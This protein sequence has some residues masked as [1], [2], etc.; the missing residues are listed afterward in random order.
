MDRNEIY[1]QKRSKVIVIEGMGD[2][3]DNYVA[4]VMR[5]IESLGFIFSRPLFDRLKTLTEPQLEKFYKEIV[6]VLK[7]MVGA[8][9]RHKP[10]YPNFPKQVME[11][12]EVEL[13]LNA[14]AHYWTASLQ[15]MGAIGDTWLPEYEAEERIPLTEKHTLKIINIG[16]I[17]DFREI[18]T[19]LVGSKSSISEFDKEIV[20][21]FVE[22]FGSDIEPILPA[23][24]PFKEQLCYVASLFMKSGVGTILTKY[25][26]TATDVLRIAAGM[27]DG[28]I[29]LAKPC[30]F[31][32]FSRA[33]RKFLLSLLENCDNITEDMFRHEKVWVK[34]LHSLHV[35]DYASRFPKA[36]AA[37]DVLRNNKPFET[38]NSKVEKLICS[39]VD[40]AVKLLYNRPSD[41]ARR[42]DKILRE[43]KNPI[44]AA[45]AL[46]D[47]S[48][49]ISTPVLLQL[50]NHFLNRHKYGAVRSFFPKGQVSKVKVI[51][52]NLPAIDSHTIATVNE[53]IVK[54]L[55]KRFAKH[56]WGNVY[57]DESLKGYIV[58]MA[59]RNASKQ[60]KTVARGSKI[61]LGGDKDTLRFFIW[62][63]NN[64]DDRVDI[65][66]SA[67]FLNDDFEEASTISYYN[68]REGKLGCHSGD[69]TDAPDGASEFIDVHI[70]S[71]A[72]KA[73]YLVM[74]VNS[75]TGQSYKNLTECFA[76]WMTRK[77]VNSG[78]IFEAKAVQ[79]KF[80]LSGETKIMVPVIFDL[81]ERK[82]IW[83]DMSL[84]N[85]PSFANNVH[86]NKNSLSKVCQAIAT[87][88]RPNLYDL[89]N[90]HA[91]AN[92]AK[93]ADSKE[94][95]D[96][97]FDESFAVETD[98]ILT[99]FL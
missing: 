36:F 5:N 73:R 53:Y 41:L 43:A 16:S 23:A 85:Y 56:K 65:D 59:Q 38:F 77:N 66:L 86:N 39:D 15:D 90:L 18:F 48:D 94:E 20:K 58:P 74:V 88:N 99:E 2:L 13:Y 75:Y 22:L 55:L 92:K 98:R 67:L 27:N 44:T 40:E 87:L 29:S 50:Y 42:L 45:I 4:T 46:D 97:I 8:H 63:K 3:S 78:E 47:V 51:D 64:G 76:G 57:I 52:N 1:L 24:I 19:M 25:V 12:S 37:A 89:V 62:W 79:N 91:M 96:L 35:G 54:A 60:L 11:M 80:D 28:D 14:I 81:E 72:K 71:A 30:K 17:K 21:W 31:K 61:Q 83:T 10:M 33:E 7:K 26:K 95:A 93:H 82:A 9:V 32:S 84:K 69:I 34:L 70:P 6:P 68:L 49:K